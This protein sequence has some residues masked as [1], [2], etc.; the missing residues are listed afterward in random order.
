MPLVDFSIHDVEFITFFHAKVEKEIFDK[1]K[2][3]CFVF[4]KQKVTFARAQLNTI[5]F[6]YKNS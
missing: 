4:L 3:F 6:T 2:T 1:N 5:F